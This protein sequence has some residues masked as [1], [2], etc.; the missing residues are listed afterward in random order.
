MM[1]RKTPRGMHSRGESCKL[2]CVVRPWGRG[3]L[4]CMHS[5]TLAQGPDL[6]EVEGAS[7]FVTGPSNTNAQ[8]SWYMSNS[9]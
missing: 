4:M 9:L 2:G 1:H 3:L 5:V 7:R 6:P 8:S